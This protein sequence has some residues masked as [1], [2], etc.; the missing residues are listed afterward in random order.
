MLHLH[1]ELDQRK[2]TR[3]ELARKRRNHEVAN[4]VKRRKLDESGTW[5]WWQVRTRPYASMREQLLNKC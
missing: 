1:A 3:L 4:V 2:D 5:S